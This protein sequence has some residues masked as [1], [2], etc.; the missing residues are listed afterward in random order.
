MSEPSNGAWPFQEIPEEEGLD[1]S[2]IFGDSS[3]A[4][5]GDPFAPPAAAQSVPSSP[6]PVAQEITPA[7]AATSQPT[8]API[9]KAPVEAPAENPIA[10]AFEQKTAENTKKGLLEKPPVF[11]HKGVKEEID[12]PSMTFEELRIRNLVLDDAVDV[13]GCCRKAEELFELYQRCANRK[14]IETICVN[15]LRGMEAT[16]LSVTGHMYFVPRTFMERVDIFE[17]FITLLSGLN[18]KQTPLLVNSFYIIDDAKQRDK[19]TEE[20][21]LAVKK[22]IAA[23]QEKCDYLIKSSS[24]SPAVMERW[25]LKVQAL[26]EKKRH[27]EG[28][29]QRELDGLDDEFSVL[30]LL[31]QE[32]QVR[33]NGIRN[34]RF[35][36]RAA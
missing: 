33:A 14:Q 29:L 28:V 27:Y 26:E 10:A 18:K 12:D 17:D 9:A 21:Y 5:Q 1:I 30:K 8:T 3:A 15:F 32:L 35:Q 6:T 2:A 25:V 34:L 11:Y 22:E 20:F 24:Q 36:Q 7:V 31:S 4:P 16:K 23:Y 13:Q 19:M